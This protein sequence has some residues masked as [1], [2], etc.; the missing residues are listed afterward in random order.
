MTSADQKI[1]EQSVDDILNLTQSH[2]RDLLKGPQISVFVGKNRP[3]RTHKRFAIAASTVINAHF[4]SK[5]ETNTYR[6]KDAH[7]SAAA[8]RTL[9]YVWPRHGV[10]HF[11]MPPVPTT[12]FVHDMQL[13]RASRLLGM[14]HCTHAIHTSYVAYL[15]TKIPEYEEIVAVLESRVGYDCPLFTAMMKHLCY[16]RY[17]KY[18]E[19]P[20]EFAAF[21]EEHEVLKS[22]ME[23]EDQFIKDWTRKNTESKLRS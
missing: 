14:E 10:N 7:T 6:L 8:V 12:T 2:R 4:V 18:I 11:Q 5:P 20:E 1:I 17:M 22:A 19:D 13:L 16:V 15:T 3:F 9:L 21:L 23:K